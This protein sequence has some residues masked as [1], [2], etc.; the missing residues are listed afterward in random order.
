MK[1]LKAIRNSGGITIRFITGI[2]LYRPANIRQSRSV[3]LVK[4]DIFR[5]IKLVGSNVLLNPS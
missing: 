2:D 3:R 1:V 5:N 4:C